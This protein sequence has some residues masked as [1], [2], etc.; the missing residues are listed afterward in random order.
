MFGFTC[1]SA[2]KGQEP[3]TSTIKVNMEE[4]TVVEKTEKTHNLHQAQMELKRKEQE[5]KEEQRRKAEENARRIALEA[6]R[7]AEE[8][9]IRE[10]YRVFEEMRLQRE[11]AE[12]R[13]A[14][15]EAARAEAERE[16]LRLEHELQE[17]KQAVLIFL[18]KHGFKDVNGCKRSL[19]SSTYP[20]HK[21]V[22][23]G[24]ERL[25]RMLIQEGADV[26]QKNSSGRTPA[27]LAAKKNK[28]GSHDKVVAAIFDLTDITAPAASGKAGGA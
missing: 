14:A 25:V 1:S 18:S 27:E 13:Q 12:M 24:D 17:R 15:A 28:A 2:C 20:L 22:E 21:A 16:R 10:Q 26:L 3:E 8:L 4:L 11:S 7:R 9:R 23:A 19:M 5:A 6:E